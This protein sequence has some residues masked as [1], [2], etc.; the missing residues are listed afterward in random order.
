MYQEIVPGDC[1][2][3][4]QFPYAIATSGA[5]SWCNGKLLVQSYILVHEWLL[6]PGAWLP[7]P[8]A[9][10]PSPGEWHRCNYP[11]PTI[12]H[13]IPL[14][15]YTTLTIYSSYIC[16]LEEFKVPKKCLNRKKLSPFCGLFY[17]DFYS[18]LIF[19]DTR[20]LAANPR[21]PIIILVVEPQVVSLLAVYPPYRIGKFLM[22]VNHL[23]RSV[24]AV[25]SPYIKSFNHR[26]PIYASLF[27][28]YASL[29]YYTSC[30]RLLTVT[31]NYISL[32]AVD[33]LYAIAP[34]RLHYCTIAPCAIPF[35]WCNGAIS[36]CNLTFLPGTFQMDFFTGHI[37]V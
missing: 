29:I 19:Y 7:S 1:T 2:I 22:A 27:A 15:L 12:H 36:W 9:M 13:P 28:V 20:V 3:A 8:G 10:V 4:R 18:L 35:S 30:I 26:P 33:P 11:I 5:I 14:H 31:P 21:Y 17:E 16:L 37:S 34:R 6:S 32:L 23:Y 24:L 25:Q